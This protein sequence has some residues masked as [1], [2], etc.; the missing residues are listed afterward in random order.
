MPDLSLLVS[1]GAAV[2]ALIAGVGAA[3]YC[4]YKA[5]QV[6][7]VV[8]KAQ[9][10]RFVATASVGIGL[11]IAI[12]GGVVT[13]ISAIVLLNRKPSPATSVVVQPEQTEAKGATSWET[14]GVATQPT[15]AP[16]ARAPSA[17]A[18][19]YPDPYGRFDQRW[20]DGTSWSPYVLRGGEQSQDPY[21]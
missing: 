13:V 19:W 21:P 14:S 7:D 11:Y 4:I 16:A 3:G 8:N 18:A 5:T 1:F 20:Y 15:P 9:S 17:P 6:S 12:A 2:F 10:N